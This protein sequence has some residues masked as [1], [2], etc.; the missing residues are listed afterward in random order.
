MT[1]RRPMFV[2]PEFAFHLV[3]RPSL[4]GLVGRGFCIRC[5]RCAWV[6]KADSRWG[7]LCDTTWNTFDT[8]G[9]CPSCHKQWLMTMCLSCRAMTPHTAWYVVVGQREKPTA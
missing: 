4:L 5:P 6:P 8:G 2:E 9:Q 1:A 7:C 3:G